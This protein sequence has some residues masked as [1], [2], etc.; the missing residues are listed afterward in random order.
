M[1][2]AALAEPPARQFPMSIGNHSA[3]PH[4][5]A[6]MLKFIGRRRVR[7]EEAVAEI[8][9]SKLKPID[10]P[11]SLGRIGNSLLDRQPVRYDMQLNY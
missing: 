7:N 4:L 5:N 6:P 10:N 9:V 1:L 8:Q 3:A 11:L 2:F